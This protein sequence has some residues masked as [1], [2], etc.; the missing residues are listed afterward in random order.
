MNFVKLV[1]FLFIVTSNIVLSQIEVSYDVEYNMSSKISDLIANKKS[2]YELYEPHIS[3]IRNLEGVL[4]VCNNQ[5]YFN[6]VDNGAG[7]YATPILTTVL[8]ERSRWITDN[9]K[10]F[11]ISYSEGLAIEADYTKN[12]WVF[13]G[14]KKVISGYTCQKAYKK[15]Y[16]VSE[17]KLETLLVVWFTP[18]IPVTSGMMDATGIPGLI[19]LYTDYKYK[20]IAKQVTKLDK[21]KINVPELKKI[22]FTEANNAAAVRNKA[23]GLKFDD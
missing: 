23:R 14:D 22:T 18:D 9:E 7:N 4:L 1:T 19:L 10:A 11:N 15:L 12:P 13:T 20:F 17:P 5:S 2:G 16:Y 8:M 6:V 3:T 21:C